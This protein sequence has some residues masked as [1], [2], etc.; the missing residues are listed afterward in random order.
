MRIIYLFEPNQQTSEVI[1]LA[2]EAELGVKVVKFEDLSALKDDI[3]DLEDDKV[4]HL[5][6]S[7]NQ[8]Q[9]EKAAKTIANF[10]Y[11]EKLDIPM[12]VLGPTEISGKNLVQLPEHFK[13]KILVKT[14]INSLRMTN[15]EI[16]EFKLPDY[17]PMPIHYF[18]L[19]K[20]AC[21]DIYIQLKK[22]GEDQYIKRIHKDSEFDKETILK[23]QKQ[24]VEFLYI[25]KVDRHI[26]MDKLLGDSVKEILKKKENY[27][28]LVDITADG[29]D[30]LQGLIIELGITKHTVDL[31]K[32]TI[33]VI[34]H[35]V[36][37]HKKLTTFVKALLDNKGS[38]NYRHCF[39]ITLLGHG[40]MSYLDW[41]K[42][43]KILKD[44][45]EKLTF[46]SLFHDMYLT[47]DKLCQ[48]S[49]SAELNDA[50]VEY[51]IDEEHVE[52]INN[53]ANLAATLIQAYPHAPSGADVIIRQHHGSMNGIGFSKD[54]GTHIS[55]IA[56][57]FI[58]LEEF[59]VQLFKRKETQLGVSEILNLLLE[60]Y[61][62]RQY[63]TIIEALK[64][65][66]IDSVK[67]QK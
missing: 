29:H 13:V 55:P 3:D 2:L 47:E 14:V 50:F 30:I 62:R 10:L 52:Q 43:R 20:E 25:E 4:P 37:K 6:I 41:G 57:I 42:N 32:A 36:N 44:N 5:F 58:V 49:S 11:D 67:E 53:H 9:E 1:T 31:A 21:C 8:S 28:E 63:V 54:F 65:Y 35:S 40:V 34:E 16:K 60:K 45:S 61:T 15:E 12:I 59:T 39:M 26:F 18:F 17:L 7:R 22:K 66:L 64:T 23:Y 46:V 51:E 27:E 48:I 19:T 56:I 38:Y 33:H 24:K